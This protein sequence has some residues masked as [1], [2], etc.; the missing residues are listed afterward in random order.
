M[1]GP[2]I[3][4]LLAAAGLGQRGAAR[5]LGIDERTIRR[6]VAGDLPVPR[7][8]EVALCG[9]VGGW[10]RR[11]KLLAGALRLQRQDIARA[12]TLGGI[13]TSNSA[14]HAWLSSPWAEKTGVHGQTLSKYRAMSEAEF[15]AVL[16]GLR[17]AL[18]E[19][20]GTG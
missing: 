18:D 2:D 12:A 8:V 3:R 1:T 20:D 15:D 14:A 11:L 6:Y 13:P 17:Q 19:A 16:V 9:M 10:N 7:I 5:A 4:D